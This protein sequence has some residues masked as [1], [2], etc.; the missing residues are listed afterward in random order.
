MSFG[1]RETALIRRGVFVVRCALAASRKTVGRSHL[2]VT[3]TDRP[4]AGRDQVTLA[5]L[6]FGVRPT[7]ASLSPLFFRHPE[8]AGAPAAELRSPRSR[9]HPH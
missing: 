7:L 6:I 9:N 4:V 8:D 1:G 2:P 5:P 3:S